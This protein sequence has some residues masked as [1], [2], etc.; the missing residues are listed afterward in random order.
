MEGDGI[1]MDGGHFLI[2][3]VGVGE[4]GAGRKD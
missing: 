3:G 2:H 1:E 4:K